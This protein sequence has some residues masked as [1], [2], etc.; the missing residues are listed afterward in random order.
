MGLDMCLYA[1]KYVSSYDYDFDGKEHTRRDNPEYERIIE[2]SGMGS[3][4]LLS[5]PTNMFLVSN[6]DIY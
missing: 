3:I 2:A 6:L 1:E 4:P 5:A